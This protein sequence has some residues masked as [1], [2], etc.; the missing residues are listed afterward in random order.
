M[1]HLVEEERRII[2]L[3]Q[4]PF[5]FT[6]ALKD[7]TFVDGDYRGDKGSMELTRGMDLHP[8]PGIDFTFHKTMDNDCVNSNFP[9]TGTCPV[10]P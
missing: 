5:H 9:L 7:S 8:S 4:F 1:I 6:M 3:I 2:L 10:P